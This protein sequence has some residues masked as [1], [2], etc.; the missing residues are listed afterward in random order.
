M[1]HTMLQEPTVHSSKMDQW[2]LMQ[3]DIKVTEVEVSSS[4]I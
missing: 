3:L 4:Q 1:D 2:W